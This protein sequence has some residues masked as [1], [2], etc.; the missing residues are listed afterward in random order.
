VEWNPKGSIPSL[1]TQRPPLRSQAPAKRPAV[2]RP[3][4]SRLRTARSLPRSR[5][6]QWPGIA[7]SVWNSPRCFPTLCHSVGAGP[8]ALQSRGRLRS[9]D[10]MA[11][12]S[13]TCAA[14]GK[15][16]VTNTTP[17]PPKLHFPFRTSRMPSQFHALHP[18]RRLSPYSPHCI[19]F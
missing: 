1:P 17:R 6:T 2:S 19:V 9:P 13:S 16:D 7:K 4:R 11:K 5:R 12:R 18:N 3:I 8:C 10:T 14:I 15:S